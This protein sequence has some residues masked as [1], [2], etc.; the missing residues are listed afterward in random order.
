MERV[1]QQPSQCGQRHNYSEQKITD[2]AE[3]EVENPFLQEV[4][5]AINKLRN[6][7]VPGCNMYGG[8]QLHKKTT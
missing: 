3:I 2:S 7:N 4:I 5:V 1:F 8:I 6:N